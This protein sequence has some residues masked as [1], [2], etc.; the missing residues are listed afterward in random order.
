MTIFLEVNLE[1]K[2][3]EVECPQCK[4]GLVHCDEFDDFFCLQCGYP[5]IIGERDD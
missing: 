3:P 4:A 1:P 5:M 2:H